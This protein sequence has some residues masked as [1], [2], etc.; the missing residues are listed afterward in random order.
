MEFEKIKNF[1]T[2]NISGGGLLN[3]IGNNLLIAGLFLWGGR[4]VKILDTKE[5]Q[6]QD[7]PSILERNWKNPIVWV[8]TALAITLFIPWTILAL[9]SKWLAYNYNYYPNL[10]G[11][12]EWTLYNLEPKT[13][14]SIEDYCRL[15]PHYFAEALKTKEKFLSCTTGKPLLKTLLSFRLNDKK[16]RKWELE[17]EMTDLIK[18][19][20]EEDLRKGVIFFSDEEIMRCLFRRVPHEKIFSLVK[21]PDWKEALLCAIPEDERIMAEFVQRL[22]TEDRLHFFNKG[23]SRRVL[24]G[25]L[26]IFYA[27]HLLPYMIKTIKIDDIK[28]GISSFE[29]VLKYFYVNI[30]YRILSDSVIS[31]LYHSHSWQLAFLIY[32]LRE[33]M[34]SEYDRV[35][36]AKYRFQI[37][38]NA[39]VMGPLF[40]FETFVEWVKK[41]E[42]VKN[43]HE[44]DQTHQLFRKRMD[45]LKDEII[46]LLGRTIFVNL[47]YSFRVEGTMSIN[48]YLEFLE[49][50]FK[51]DMERGSSYMINRYLKKEDRDLILNVFSKEPTPLK[52]H[53]SSL[54]N[55]CLHRASELGL[56]STNLPQELAH[57]LEVLKLLEGSQPD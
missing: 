29:P 50:L 32:P 13:K 27:P 52:H 40:S 16:I 49:A 11:M 5:I 56:P 30:L 20:S 34:T 2:I 46:Q 42:E 53:P 18:K 44:S 8:Q 6:Y 51:Y 22:T 15:N 25:T 54:V 4:T 19:L 35:L 21:D 31:V 48:A 55:I 45:L 9:G 1:L 7:I 14:E 36:N 47:D 37:N 39:S 41:E 26:S 10:K 3:E 57:D 33:L 28:K 43:L 17:E 24:G 23:I 38:T 12:Y